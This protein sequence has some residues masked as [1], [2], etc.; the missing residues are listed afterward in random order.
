MAEWLRN[1]Q[2]VRARPRLW[3]EWLSLLE[4]K[5]PL[6]VVRKVSLHP[7]MNIVWA[8]EPEGDAG[9]SVE[10]AGHG[11]GK[12]SF[13]LLL[14][15]CLGDEAPSITALREKAAAGF[16]KGSV[17]ALVHI[18]GVAWVV[19]RPYGLYAQS[20]AGRGDSVESLL[21]GD[22]DGNYQDFLE[23]LRRAFIETL[24]ATTLPGTNQPLEWRH[25]LAWCVRDQKT[26][27]DTFFH[28]RDGDALGFRRP[29]QDPPVL[30][31]AV[32]GLH[33]QD[34]DKLMREI[35][36]ADASIK[37]LDAELQELERY[38]AYA[39]A[40]AERRIRTRLGAADDRPRPSR[41][42]KQQTNSSRWNSCVWRK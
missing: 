30:V 16:P 7:G 39:A 9:P 17:A 38:P 20:L 19:Y 15:Y 13:C 29:R 2:P 33:D 40:A 12:T 22:L 35:E 5:E 42:S 24:T 26:R 31:Q 23:S 8:R 34:V 37:T 25:L 18:D 10:S 28:W 21:A 36:S 27:F 6:T 14:R 4:S 3:V 11:V 32:L 1:F 41:S